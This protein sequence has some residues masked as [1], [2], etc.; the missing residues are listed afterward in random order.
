M[1]RRSHVYS[2]NQI[3][4]SRSLRR[5]HTRRHPS[6][7]PNR[8][9]LLFVRSLLPPRKPTKKANPNQR[10][11]QRMGAFKACST[12][13]GAVG[14]LLLILLAQPRHYCAD[15][16]VKEKATSISFREKVKLPGGSASA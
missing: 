6:H 2:H 14:A 7:H 16:D 3:D 12:V 15:A 8:C 10:R 4:G 13:T 9:Y 1:P 11:Q 5:A